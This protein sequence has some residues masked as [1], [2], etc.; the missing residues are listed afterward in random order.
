MALKKR[1]GEPKKKVEPEAERPGGQ[2][3]PVVGIGASAGGLDA[4]SE[5]LRELPHDTGM[6]IVFVQ[7]LDP[8]HSSILS[9]LLG[10]VTTMPVEAA[11]DGM[12]VAGNHIYVIPPNTSIA[13]DHG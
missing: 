9:E 7:H 3:C 13:L 2:N 1:N 12:R 10:R 4:M 6:A 11:E 5:I 8:K